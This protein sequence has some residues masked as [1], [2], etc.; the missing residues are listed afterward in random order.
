MKA[1]AEPPF[2]SKATSPEFKTIKQRHCYKQEGPARPAMWLL[3]SR[4]FIENSRKVVHKKAPAE[5][6]FS[7]KAT[8]A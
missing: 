3:R 7:S 1:P 6:P 5:P 4:L 2:S 8:S